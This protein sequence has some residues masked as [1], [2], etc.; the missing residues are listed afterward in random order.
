MSAIKQS[1]KQYPNMH[2]EMHYEGQDAMKHPRGSNRLSRVLKHGSQLTRQRHS[3]KTGAGGPG[4]RQVDQHAEKQKEP[5]RIPITGRWPRELSL[6]CEGERSEMRPQKEVAAAS[7]GTWTHARPLRMV[8][9]HSLT[10]LCLVPP[11]L[12]LTQL[13]IIYLVHPEILSHPSFLLRK[14]L[15]L[16]SWASLSNT[17]L[18]SLFLPC[19]HF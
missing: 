18:K 8:F 7:V 11:S 5:Q 19:C 13:C 10:A 16:S 6:K 2:W 17:S 3:R 9:I 12:P 4:S 1:H 14:P 15:R